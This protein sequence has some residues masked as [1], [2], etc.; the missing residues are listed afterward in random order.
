MK[1]VGGGKNSG[2][3]SA[4]NPLQKKKKA[5]EQDRNKS[6]GKKSVINERRK[7]KDLPRHGS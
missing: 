2:P 5:E 3:E 4:K 6:R 1:E 7:G